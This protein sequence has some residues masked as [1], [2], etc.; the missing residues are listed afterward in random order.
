[1]AACASGTPL[2]LAGLR[3]CRPHEPGSPRSQG[4][5]IDK[6]DSVERGK[7]FFHEPP[8]SAVKCPPGN[9]PPCPRRSSR[10]ARNPQKP[11]KA[12]WASPG[13]G[14][15]VRWTG[16][17]AVEELPA[18]ALA[19]PQEPY[20]PCWISSIRKNRPTA[21]LAKRKST[22]TKAQVLAFQK[23][24]SSPKMSFFRS[25]LVGI[26]TDTKPKVLT[27]ALL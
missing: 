7:D 5:E 26:P 24:P 19:K 8:W 13:D 21:V 18:P 9:P 20:P 23:S 14:F 25:D 22:G 27:R 3:R 16:R 6:M 15:L 11:E 1:M 17:G 10:K 2:P 4:R 12:L